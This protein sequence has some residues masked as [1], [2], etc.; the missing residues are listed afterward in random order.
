MSTVIFMK[1]GTF[2]LVEASREVLRTVGQATAKV[3]GMELLEQGT[4]IRIGDNCVDL[5]IENAGEVTAGVSAG[6]TLT[7]YRDG[8]TVTFFQDLEGEAKI[9]VSGD[10]SEEKLR[11]IGQEVSNRLAQQYAYHRLV[12]EMKGRGMNIVEEEVEQDGTVR[13]Q[14][15]VYQG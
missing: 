12:T 14:V 15:R 9:R 8:I 7:F 13:M 5:E 3:M 1:G 11:A 10:A 2:L 6:Q 4:A